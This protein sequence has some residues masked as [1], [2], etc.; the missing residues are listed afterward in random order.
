MTL[1]QHPQTCKPLLDI[2]FRRG[3]KAGEVRRY[4]KS[5]EAD[6]Y[7]Q[8]FPY[9]NQM[10]QLASITVDAYS[11]GCFLKFFFIRLIKTPNIQQNA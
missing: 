9:W 7:S 6:A 10:Q 2:F 3:E 1:Q 11:E 5:I 8:L 4:K